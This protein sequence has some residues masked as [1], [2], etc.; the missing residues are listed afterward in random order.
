MDT[1]LT[2]CSQY[3]LMAALLAVAPI[4][5]E[6]SDR[7]YLGASVHRASLDLSGGGA[8]ASG[9][10]VGYKA[11]AGY[12][13]GERLAV[14]ASWFGGSRVHASSATG[15]LSALTASLSHRWLAGQFDI[16]GRAGA[17]YWRSRVTQAGAPGSRD[18]FVDPF[19]GAG[20][21]YGSGKVA[22]RAD[23]DLLPRRLI[24][25][26]DGAGTGGG[27]ADYWSVGVIWRRR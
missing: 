5:A 2:R 22:V 12:H 23:F 21:Q 16:L 26:L 14:E 17:S 8:S 10:D 1:S 4:V 9:T 20:I 3:L 18:R 27:W 24:N 25:T 15:E 11:T 19:I 6:A 13:I 7:L